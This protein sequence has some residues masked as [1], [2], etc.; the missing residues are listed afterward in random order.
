M[1]NTSSRSPP[2]FFSPPAMSSSPLESLFGGL[3]ADQLIAEEQEHQATQ[4]LAHLVPGRR[5]S[6]L[7]NIDSDD[8]E[9]LIPGSES[10]PGLPSSATHPNP[11]PLQTEQV[12]HRMAR[13]LKFSKENVSV[14]EQFSQVSIIGHCLTRT[15]NETVVGTFVGD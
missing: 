6:P 1:T 13:R 5:A 2:T 14:V 4:P 9:P 8:E 10:S 15:T 3:N 11:A 7:G 12:I